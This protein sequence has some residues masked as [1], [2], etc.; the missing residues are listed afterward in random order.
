LSM[1]WEFGDPV[2]FGAGYRELADGE[3]IPEDAESYITHTWEPVGPGCAG[4]E[5]K[6]ATKE[7]KNSWYH[8]P[9][10]TP[11]A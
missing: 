3:V 10:R 1:H 8:F 11:S 5:Y 7:T 4:E 6:K 2:D 9:I